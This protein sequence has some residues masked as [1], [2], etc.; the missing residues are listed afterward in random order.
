MI[1]TSKKEAMANDQNISAQ[2]NFNV[3]EG[4]VAT[5]RSNIWNGTKVK[6]KMSPIC[7]IFENVRM[8]HQKEQKFALVCC[9]IIPSCVINPNS[10][11]EISCLSSKLMFRSRL[12]TLARTTKV[13]RIGSH[14]SCRSWAK[15]GIQVPDEPMWTVIDLNERSVHENVLKCPALWKIHTCVTCVKITYRTFDNSEKWEYALGSSTS[16]ACK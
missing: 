2:Q 11:F 7:S 1:I 13:Q 3:F 10:T 16:N 5:R 6:W 4:W 14:E 9:H 8:E 15:L 12:P